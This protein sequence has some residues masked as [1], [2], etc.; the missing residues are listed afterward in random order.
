M[1][2]RAHFIAGL[3]GPL[4]MAMASSM[5]ING[6]DFRAVIADIGKS[7]ALILFSGI[8]TLVA[9]LAIVRLH[10]VWSGGWQI[11]VSIF[12][13]LALIG[14]FVRIVLPFQTAALAESFANTGF[15]IPVIALFP[16][17]LGAYLSWQGWRP[18]AASH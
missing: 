16:L 2:T 17:V 7:P 14:G 4:L 5:L 9:G 3:I 18:V 15:P 13:W 1:T 12:G 8:V 10:N 11:I 6:N